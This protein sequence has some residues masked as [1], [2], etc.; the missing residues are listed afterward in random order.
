MKL[1]TFIRD[2]KK[3]IGVKTDDGTV[4]I[5]AL[6]FPSE[7]NDIILGGD[8]LLQEIEAAVKG[9]EPVGGFE[10]RFGKITEPSKIVCAGLN[11]SDHAAET[12]GEA[13]E[14]PVFFSKFNDALHPAGE[15]VSLPAWQKCYDYEA[16]LVI[17][18]G[19]S[20][21][22]IPEEDAFPHIFG[23][24]CGN[25]LSMRDAQFLSSQWLA[26]KSFPCSAPAGPY[27][28]TRDELDPDRAELD[29]ICDRGGEIVQHGNTRDMLFSCRSIL[30]WASR[31]FALSPGDLIFTGTP[32]GVIL[33]RPKESRRWLQR[34]ET[35]IVRIDGI[36]ELVTPLI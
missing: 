27:I 35:V 36:G 3:C 11:Y 28:V 8:E 33:G 21:W 10:L 32:A 5:T 7:M 1:C 34:G 20:A 31:F 14:Y 15:A 22:N 4:D 6:G 30:S 29:V 2:E 13:P 24:A 17:V 18:V 26:G 23:F 12:G 19:K 25:D 16:E 9:A